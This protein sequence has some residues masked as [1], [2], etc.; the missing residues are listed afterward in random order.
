MAEGREVNGRGSDMAIWT[1]HRCTQNGSTI[2]RYNHILPE[3]R[4]EC[5]KFGNIK[6]REPEMQQKHGVLYHIERHEQK[7]FFD[8]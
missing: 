6:Y 4:S 8:K 3:I 1:E 5:L 7:S 2:N